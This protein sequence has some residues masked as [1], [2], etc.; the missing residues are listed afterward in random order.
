VAVSSVVFGLLHV[1]PFGEV[2]I[3]V[4]QVIGGVV[5]AAA[6]AIRWSV[7]SAMVVDAMGNL[8]VGTL[9]FIYVRLFETCPTLYLS[10]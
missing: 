8:F 5:M 2:G 9:L 7:I 10:Q 1:V 4:P 6:F 3:A